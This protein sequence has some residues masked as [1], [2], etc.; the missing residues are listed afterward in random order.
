[1]PKLIPFRLILS[2]QGKR[3]K[4]LSVFADRDNSIYVHPYRPEGEPWFTTGSEPT[5]S[6]QGVRIN[7]EAFAPTPMDLQKLTL[8]SDGAVHL[9]CRNGERYRKVRGPAFSDMSM[10]YDFGAFVP[11]HPKRLPE[12][13][14]SRAFDV[15]IEFPDMPPPVYAVLSL[16]ETAAPP[17][18]VQGPVIPHPL[19]FD[20]PGRR[21]GVALTMWPVL[22]QVA[23]QEVQWPPAPFFLYRT[24]A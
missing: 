20:F 23:E 16:F 17:L 24:A 3:H 12:Y 18:G 15:E 6:A 1:M 8:H 4:F 10:P 7:F 21:Y 22:H 2:V 13:T 9:K 11:C 14:K 5:G 19:C